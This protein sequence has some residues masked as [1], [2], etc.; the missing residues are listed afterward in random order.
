MCA[1]DS[2]GALRLVCEPMTVSL[3][4]ADHAARD[5]LA[6][7][8]RAR[9][10][11]KQSLIGLSRADMAEALVAAGVPERQVRM[12]VQQIW[13]WLYVRGVA[14]FGDMLNVSKELR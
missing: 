5:A 2:F 1:P 12:R 8:A 14:D 4:L 10:V 11:E 7:Q 13:H 9:F 6:R 3:D